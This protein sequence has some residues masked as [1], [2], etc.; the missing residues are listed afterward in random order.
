MDHSAQASRE[1]GALVCPDG[2][3]QRRVEGAVVHAGKGVAIGVLPAWRETAFS[4]GWAANS[5][6]PTHASP[7]TPRLSLLQLVP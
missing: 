3:V 6:A 1:G 4:L 7:V 5:R 2:S